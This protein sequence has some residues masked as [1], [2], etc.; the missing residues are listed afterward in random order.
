M[1][2]SDAT[3]NIEE[4]NIQVSLVCTLNM[5]SKSQAQFKWWVYIAQP[6]WFYM[7]GTYLT[8]EIREIPIS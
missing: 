5:D 3:Y 4:S 2:Y 6:I 1:F 8:N 7:Q